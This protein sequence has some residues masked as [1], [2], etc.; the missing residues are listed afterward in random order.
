MEKPRNRVV[1]VSR[2]G[3]PEGLEVVDAS[4]DRRSCWAMTSSGKS[5]ISAKK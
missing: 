1:Q 5:M 4:S 2:F 3:G